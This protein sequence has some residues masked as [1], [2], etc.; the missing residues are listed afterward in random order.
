MIKRTLYF[1]SAAY[2]KKE[3][4]QLKIDF[5]K[6]EKKQARVIPIEDIGILILDHPRLTITQGLLQALIENNAAL[7]S[8]NNSHLP[9][10]L[11]MPMSANHTYTEKLKYQLESSEPL[12]KKLWQQTVRA[13]I[14][15]QAGL[16]AERGVNIENMRYWAS[17]VRSGDPDNLEGRAAANYWVKLIE[18]KEPFRRGRFEE[19]PNNLLNY[20]Y[21]VLRALVARSLVASGML[22]AVGIHHRNKYNPFCLADDVMEPYRPFVDRLVLDICANY[23]ADEIELLTTEVKR[24]LLV[25]PILDVLIDKQQSPLMLGVQRTTAS[26]MQCY[27]GQRKK[28]L[29]PVFQ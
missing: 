12:R 22:P 21:A 2:L 10:G 7:L 9:V 17:K 15:N 11:F 16:L 13:K 23:Q 19:P 27:E 3:Q 24:D 8:C 6:E 20:G 18:G 1:G 26:L 28:I 4:D 14:E 29:Y 5:P 25:L